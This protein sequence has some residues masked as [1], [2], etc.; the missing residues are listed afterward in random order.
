MCQN[1]DDFNLSPVKGIFVSK[2]VCR[3]APFVKLNYDHVT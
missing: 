3:L 2:N 1:H